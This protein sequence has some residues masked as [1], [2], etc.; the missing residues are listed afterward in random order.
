MTICTPVRRP[1]T[2]RAATRSRA[3][4][5][6]SRQHH[7]ASAIA[8]CVVLAG[9]QTPGI[10]ASALSK[11]D[12][13]QLAQMTSTD[14]IHGPLERFAIAAG[15][16]DGEKNKKRQL[17]NPPAAMAAYKKGE[18][19]FKEKRYVEAEEVF[20]KETAE[21]FAV[22][23]IR[24]DAIFMT[25]E[26]LFFQKNYAKAQD[27]YDLCIKEYSATR[28]LDE[29]SRR[30]FEIARIWLKYPDN[31]TASDV[32]PV[33][34]DEPVK[35]APPQ[36]AWQ[37]PTDWT[38]RIPILPNL[39]D[40]SRPVF[41]TEGRALEALKSIWLNDPTGP[42]ADDSIMLSASYYLRK[43]D[44]TEADHLYELLRKEFPRSPHVENAYVLGAYVKLMEYQGPEYDP[45]PLRDAKKL[46]E[47]IL[48][49][50]P[51][52]P[53]HERMLEELKK[54][55]LAEA[56]QLWAEV[57]YRKAK[58]QT[59]G[60][61]IW[62]KDIIKKYPHTEFAVMAREELAKIKP[63]DKQDFPTPRNYEETTKSGKAVVGD[64]PG[65]FEDPVGPPKKAP[66]V[67]Q[68]FGQSQM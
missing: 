40:K 1:H 33:N 32:K 26:C 24:E 8:F 14:D 54:I 68:E 60:V 31:I 59:K 63:E 6:T 58:N 4:W 51:H 12:E 20:W 18:E 38:Y 42:L 19:L 52:R 49:L 65:V 29:I 67:T 2:R 25:G 62:C 3:P 64:A 56:A 48:R 9:C 17:M 23:P 39:S 35:N 28:H 61:A 55:E 57:K 53:D 27:K 46:K 15:F 21:K 34:F 30:K 41:D 37:A 16:K 50:Y 44:Y 47:Q 13:E 45:T 5:R 22:F 66:P 10:D 11:K 36:T 43:G 7:L